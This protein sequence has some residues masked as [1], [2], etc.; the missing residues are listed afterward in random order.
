[1]GHLAHLSL[2]VERQSQKLPEGGGGGGA[3]LESHLTRSR[4]SLNYMD[5]YMRTFS[6]G[7]APEICH[8]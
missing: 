8:F 6:F 3:L 2:S 4:P 7:N 5:I 1:M